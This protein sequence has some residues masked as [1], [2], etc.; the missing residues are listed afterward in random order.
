MSRK[1]R[2]SP[3][4]PATSSTSDG[5]KMTAPTRPRASPRRSGSAPFTVTFFFRRFRS[6]AAAR[7]RSPPS[8]SRSVPSMRNTSSPKRT[9]CSS[10]APRKERKISR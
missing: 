6:K 9:S 4:P 3:G 2:R 5:E 1:R 8:G 10:G 7:V